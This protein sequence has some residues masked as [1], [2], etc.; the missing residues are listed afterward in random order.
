MPLAPSDGSVFVRLL[1]EQVQHEF[2]AS[3]QYVALAVWFD[4]RDL[5][6]LAAHFYRQ[7]VE[8]RNHAMML[9]QY[10]LDRDIEVRIPGVPDVLNDF[11]KPVELIALSLR[12]EQAVTKQIEALFKAARDEDDFLGEQF[13]LWFLK[14]QV[15]EVS[16]RSTLLAVAERAGDDVWQ[17]EDFLS[18]ES[19]GDAGQ[20]PSAPAAAGG[21]L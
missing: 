6:R 1:R 3:Q 10:M 13:M 5:P 7:A 16:S 9:V 19:V 14:E 2:A 15:E 12:Q 4:A 11:S 18:R 20:D 21:A 17:I 8:E